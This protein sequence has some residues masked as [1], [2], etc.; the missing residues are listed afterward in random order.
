MKL[1]MV[2]CSSTSHGWTPVLWYADTHMHTDML[3]PLPFLPRPQATINQTKED[4]N[5]AME[6]QSFSPHLRMLLG[7]ASVMVTTK[8]KVSPPQVPPPA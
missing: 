2:P 1:K 7:E 6:M 3:Q 5:E 4:W 8:G